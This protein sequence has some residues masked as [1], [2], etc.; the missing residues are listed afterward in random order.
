MNSFERRRMIPVADDP[1]IFLIPISFVLCWA[2]KEAKP[3]SPRHEMKMAKT[4]EKIEI[5]S[6]RFSAPVREFHRP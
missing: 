5:F 6:R 1:R 2:V 3:R 4:V